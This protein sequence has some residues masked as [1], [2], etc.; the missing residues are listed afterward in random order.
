ML[1][2]S[3]LLATS[4]LVLSQHAVSQSRAQAPRQSADSLQ[5]QY[6]SAQSFQRDGNLTAAAQQYRAFL[7][8]ALTELAMGYAVVP[9]YESAFSLFDD[10]LALEPNSPSLLLEYAHTS[11]AAGDLPHTRTLASALVNSP[12]A[13]PQQLAEAHQILGRVLLKLTRDQDARKEFEAA[14][15]LDPTF[16]NGYDLAVA[17]LDLDDD[18]CAVN[19]FAEMQRSFGDTAEIHF[20]FARAY[21]DS[22]FQPRAITELHRAIELNPRL[23]GEHYLLAALLLAT[24]NA[25][26]PLEAAEAELKKELAL[27]PNDATSYAALG[28]IKLAEKVYP[29]AEGFLKRSIALAPKDPDAYLYLGQLYFDTDQPDKAESALRESIAL[30]TDVSRNRFQ[31]QKAHYLLGRILMKQGK[32]EAAHAEMT[33]SRDLADKTLAQDKTKLAALTDS[34][35][36]QDAA[37]SAAQP[38]TPGPPTTAKDPA[39]LA[40]VEAARSRLAPAVADAYNNLGAIAATKSNF[41]TAVVFFKDAALWN[42][43]LE[44]L[45]FNWGRAAFAGS[46]FNEAIAPLSRYTQ[47]HPSDAGARGALGFSQFMT[48]DYRAARATL[49][50]IATT[51]DL[52]PQIEYAY[53]ESLIKT[54]S[55]NEGVARLTT[56]EHAHPEI[57]DVHHAL[58]E[59]YDRLGNHQ[60]AQDELATYNTLKSK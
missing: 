49:A 9:D 18:K 20:A 22:D 15:A 31:V 35:S 50:P 33:I 14:V 55:V 6:L 16:A 1:L 52:A 58:S 26:T 37:A 43:K 47:T 2:R 19:I 5:Q 32:P 17:C 25:A 41:A 11:L 27:R 30:T 24:T 46:L 23:P 40:R 36:P 3:G 59:A 56:L 60:R 29:E 45:D 28:K 8:S 4:L 12:A 54:G 53:A 44:G 13:T 48:G 42:P 10:V 38:T 21:G 51:S 7:G 39:A 57:P 34:R